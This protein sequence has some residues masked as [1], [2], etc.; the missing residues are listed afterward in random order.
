[1]TIAEDFKRGEEAKLNIEIKLSEWFS[2][3]IDE[4]WDYDFYYDEYNDVLVIQLLW[5]WNPTVEFY[6]ELIGLGFDAVKFRD[7][8]NNST[9]CNFQLK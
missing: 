6:E 3:N 9:Y 8:N 4:E 2:K 7:L 5:D 1:M